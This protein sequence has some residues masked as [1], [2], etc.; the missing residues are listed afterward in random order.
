MINAFTN[1]YCKYFLKRPGLVKRVSFYVPNWLSFYA[2]ARNELNYLLRCVRGYRITCLCVEISSRCN[3]NC[4]MCARHKVM[5]RK[6]ADMTMDTFTTLVDKNPEVNMYILVGWGEMMLN[7]NFFPM[8]DYLRERGKRMALTSNATLFTED[9]IERI[10]KSGISHITV[11]MDGIDEVYESIRGMSYKKIEGNLIRLSNRIKETGSRIYLEINSIGR[12]DVLQKAD[13]MR[14]RLGRHV[15]QIR[16]SS[17]IEYNN[18]LKTNRTRPCREFW[19]GMISVLYDGSV[20][21]CCMDYNATMIIGNVSEAPL[22]K[23]WNN[24]IM[25]IFRKD[26]ALLQFKRRCA[27][28]FETDS[29]AG[30]I[31]EKRFN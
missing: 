17:F 27:T 18:L 11:S 24:H 21:P 1:F 30:E 9:N 10:I 2:T 19:R 12:P 3:L 28:C 23:I 26:H 4:I 20:V 5:K 29:K 22:Q 7:K 13:E 16:F 6:Q 25:R 14:R 15:D 31:I 8:V